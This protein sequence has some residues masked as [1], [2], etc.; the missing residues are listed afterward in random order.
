[1]QVL[2]GLETVICFNLKYAIDW[3]KVINRANKN[4]RSRGFSWPPACGFPRQ[5]QHAELLR[6]EGMLGGDPGSP[7]LC[8]GAAEGTGPQSP[9]VGTRAQSQGSGTLPLNVSATE[10]SPGGVGDR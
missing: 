9:C 6:L 3:E 2:I 5:T 7:Q 10:I 4:K 8:F 1:M